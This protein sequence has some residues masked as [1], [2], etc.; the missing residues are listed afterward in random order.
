MIESTVSAGELP[1]LLTSKDGLLNN[2]VISGD[3]QGITQLV[4]SVSSELESLA[5]QEKLDQSGGTNN[6]GDGGGS[7]DNGG[8]G[9]DG[10]NGR[11]QFEDS[12]AKKS[13]MKV[14]TDI[15]PK[16]CPSLPSLSF[17][18]AVLTIRKFIRFREEE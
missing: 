10:D 18:N 7:T 16:S 9:G 5:A 8:S 17:S 13:R 14:T 2:M 3:T 11:N 15:N 12:E 6:A 4:S 1:Y